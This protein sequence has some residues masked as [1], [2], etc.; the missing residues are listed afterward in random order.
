MTD[1]FIDLDIGTGS[2]IRFAMLMTHYRKPCEMGPDKLAEARKALRRL[3]MACEP[4]LDGPP[5]EFVEIMANDLNTPGCIAKLHQYRGAGMGR[6]LFAS[7]RF[8]GFFDGK[9]LLDELKT[10]PPGSLF[11]QGQYVQLDPEGVT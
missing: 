6:E 2:V 9:A 1:R 4:N 8:L 11:G 7:M 5:V 3:A 10:Y